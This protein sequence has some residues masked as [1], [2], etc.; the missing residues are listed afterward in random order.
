MQSGLEE[1]DR[2]DAGQVFWKHHWS[3]HAGPRAPPTDY[4]PETP[5]DEA[6]PGE[7][8]LVQSLRDQNNSLKRMLGDETAHPG[9]KRPRGNRGG[10]RW[11]KGNG[12]GSNSGATVPPPPPPPGQAK[13]NGGGGQSAG[14]R[15]FAN[16][17]AARHNQKKGKGG[18]RK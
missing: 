3:W 2:I 6:H 4:A 7:S 17:Q 18:R 5:Y 1:H 15:A 8:R 14:Q 16:R 10:N 12:G 11:S 13:G 9:T